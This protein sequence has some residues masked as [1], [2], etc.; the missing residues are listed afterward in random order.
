MGLNGGRLKRGFISGKSLTARAARATPGASRRGIQA[1]GRGLALTKQELS[2]Q[3]EEIK[4]VGKQFQSSPTPKKASAK[5]MVSKKLG[6]KKKLSSKK[7]RKEMRIPRTFKVELMIA[8]GKG[9]E[10]ITRTV[11]AQ[12]SLEAVN[13]ASLNA[14]FIKVV[15]NKPTIRLARVLD[16]KGRLVGDFT[17]LGSE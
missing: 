4:G 16:T 11:Q 15:K 10:V 14:G 9:F 5:K 2:A 3:L 8:K 6:T 13:R 7:P 17:P 1:T 12:S